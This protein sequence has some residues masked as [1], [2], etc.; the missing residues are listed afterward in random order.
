LN[1]SCRSGWARRPAKSRA[2]TSRCF[3]IRLL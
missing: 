1:V 2:A 3:Q